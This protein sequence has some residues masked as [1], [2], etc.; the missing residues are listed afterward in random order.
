MKRYRSSTGLS[1]DGGGAAV[2]LSLSLCNNRFL[3]RLLGTK[4]VDAQPLRY[5]G[6]WGRKPV[7]SQ[8]G[9]VLIL[10]FARE[11]SD[12]FPGVINY[13]GPRVRG[14]TETLLPHPD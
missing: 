14:I 13:D 2:G 9:S 7:P 8:L 5:Q 1:V 11:K 3:A 6:Y 4:N 12:D 10:H